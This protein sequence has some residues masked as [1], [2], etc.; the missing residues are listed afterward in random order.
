MYRHAPTALMTGAVLASAALALCF[1]GP[2]AA[3]WAPQVSG[4]SIR[5]PLGAA[6]SIRRSGLDPDPGAGGQATARI[7]DPAG[8]LVARPTL[9]GAVAGTAGATWGS[10]DASG[11]ESP[12]VTYGIEARSEWGPARA[13]LVR[14]EVAISPAIPRD[15]L[16]PADARPV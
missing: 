16:A 15:R 4:G 14:I 12:V 10:R 13:R 5:G 9:R 6:Q 2:A 1:A 3:Q 11:S 8:R 7:Y